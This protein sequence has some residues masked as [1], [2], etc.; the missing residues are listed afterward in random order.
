MDFLE[1]CFH[2]GERPRTRQRVLQRVRHHPQKCTASGG[3]NAF[4]PKEM[5][6]TRRRHPQTPAAFGHDSLGIVDKKPP[7]TR[8]RHPQSTCVWLSQRV[9]GLRV[10]ASESVGRPALWRSEV[11][12][13]FTL[14]R[15]P[16]QD[17]TTV[18]HPGNLEAKSRRQFNIL[19]VRRRSSRR[20]RNGCKMCCGARV[21]VTK[22]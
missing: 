21:G 16:R 22:F 18:S 20:C 14:W 10:A 17:L 15:S 4:F 1:S 13:S 12:D 6:T 7:W 3:R 9:R 19:E 2:S 11:D 8:R 5:V